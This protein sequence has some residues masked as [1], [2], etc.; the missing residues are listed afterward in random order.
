M[1]L[2]EGTCSRAAVPA[3]SKFIHENNCL[4]FFFFQSIKYCPLM[5]CDT[6][7]ERSNGDY[8]V[9]LAETRLNSSENEI[10]DEGSLENND[11]DPFTF[12]MLYEFD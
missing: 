4:L 8:N 2:S 10:V 1:V 5:F 6:E 9:L 7:Y 12:P 3:R 11:D